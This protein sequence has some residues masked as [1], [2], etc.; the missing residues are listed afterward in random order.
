MALTSAAAAAAAAADVT[1]EKLTSQYEDVFHFWTKIVQ[2]DVFEGV[3]RNFLSD[4]ANEVLWLCD[5]K[6][7]CKRRVLD[8]AS[9]KC[10]AALLQFIYFMKRFVRTYVPI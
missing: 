1:D 5:I 4:R 6:D 8:I 3:V 10:K 7:N 2:Q 9:P